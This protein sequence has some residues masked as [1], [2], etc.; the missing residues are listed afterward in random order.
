M[1]EETRAK[2]FEHLEPIKGLMEEPSQN[3]EKANVLKG[4]IWKG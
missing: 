3:V 1:K 2:I 4:E